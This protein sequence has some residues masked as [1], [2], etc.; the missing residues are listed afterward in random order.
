M[1]FYG[2]LIAIETDIE[3]WELCYM[4]RVK[5]SISTTGREANGRLTA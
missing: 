2:V 3:L 1:G 5:D 4:V